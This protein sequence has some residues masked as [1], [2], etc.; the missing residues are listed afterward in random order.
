MYG[1]VYPRCGAVYGPQQP[2]CY[3]CNGETKYTVTTIWKGGNNSGRSDGKHSSTSK[4]I[5]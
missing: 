4:D 5:L 3:R 2:E 1:W